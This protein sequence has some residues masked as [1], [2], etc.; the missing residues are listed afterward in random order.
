MKKK[1]GEKGRGH[2]KQQAGGH[3]REVLF[4]QNNYWE[5]L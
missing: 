3:Q 1:R 5:W 4:S 2:L